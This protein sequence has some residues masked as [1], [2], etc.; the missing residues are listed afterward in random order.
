MVE[1][2]RVVGNRVCDYPKLDGSIELR[3]RVLD[4]RGHCWD[5]LLNS[6]DDL[7]A[8]IRNGVTLL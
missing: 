4:L 6:A 8:Y 2:D 7:H 3:Q 1:D 5:G